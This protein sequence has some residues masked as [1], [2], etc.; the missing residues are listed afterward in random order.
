MKKGAKRGLSFT[1][2]MFSSPF[3]PSPPQNLY[4]LHT[5]PHEGE[6]L[7]FFLFNSVFSPA[8]D[9][10]DLYTAR[11]W[12]TL[13]RGRRCTELWKNRGLGEKGAWGTFFFFFLVKASLN[14]S[15]PLL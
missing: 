1:A 2:M 6:V 9:C 13:C 4:M 15:L 5:K 11:G 12:L 3:A 7:F 8:G 14:D 10:F